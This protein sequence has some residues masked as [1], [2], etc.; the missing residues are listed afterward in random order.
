MSSEDGLTLQPSSVELHELERAFVPPAALGSSRPRD[1]RLTNAGRALVVVAC[2]L[3]VGALV[4][5]LV[6]ARESSRQSANRAALVERGVMT[7]GVVSRLWTDDDNRRKVQ[8][9]FE[10][11]GQ[12]FTNDR[13]VS[14]ERRRELEVGAAIN[15]RFLPGNPRVNDLGG[16][17]RNGLPAAIAPIVGFG[18]ALVGVGCLLAIR[19]QRRLL[20]DGRVAPALVT[21]HKTERSSHGKQ[22][23]MTFTFPLLSGAVAAGKGGTSK[24]A[25]A[26]GSVITVVYDPEHPT[27]SRVYPFSLV[28]PAS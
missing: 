5:S 15:V 28:R 18:L 12:S 14:A 27:R 22:Q 6:L 20:E 25:P 9:R 7:T 13:T 19:V 1:V 2:V 24:G 8:Y 4:S 3:F 26:V 10:A 11:E 23:S 21:S 16:A 17:P